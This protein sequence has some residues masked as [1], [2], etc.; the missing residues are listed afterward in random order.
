MRIRSF[1]WLSFFALAAAFAAA[2]PSTLATDQNRKPSI[3]VKASPSVGSSPL[4]AVIVAELKGG[5]NDF[6]DFYCATIEWDW[7]DGTQS[8]SRTDCDPYQAGPSE[9]TR[10]YVQEHTFLWSGMTASPPAASSPPDLSE[11]GP[12][13]LAS[14]ESPRD[15]QRPPTVQFRIRFLI[16]QQNKVVGSGKTTVEIQRGMVRE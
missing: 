4:R 5:A 9:I 6:K 16:K 3:T 7:G 2:S 13:P 15:G 1:T 10:R 12:A 11:N 14:S 8:Q